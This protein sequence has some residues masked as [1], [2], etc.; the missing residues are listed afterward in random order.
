MPETFVFHSTQNDTFNTM[1]IYFFVCLNYYF[2]CHESFGIFFS[3]FESWDILCYSPPSN[4]RAKT[5]I[6]DKNK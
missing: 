3:R 6:V 5:V 2:K 4:S 1:F